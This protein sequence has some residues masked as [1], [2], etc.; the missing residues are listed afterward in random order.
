MAILQRIVNHMD[1]KFASNDRYFS[2]AKGKK[3]LTIREQF[4]VRIAQ[5]RV[6]KEER[7]N[8]F[9]IVRE[10]LSNINFVSLFI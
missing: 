2:F 3:E 1:K 9:L 6:Q 8:L 7:D 4:Q 10:I 5:L